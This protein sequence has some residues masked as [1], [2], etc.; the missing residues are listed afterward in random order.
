M[1]ASFNPSHRSAVDEL[2]GLLKERT[3]VESFLDFS[4]YCKSRREIHPQ[5]W[6]SAFIKAQA[7]GNPALMNLRRPNSFAL[8][9]TLFFPDAAIQRDRGNNNNGHGQSQGQQDQSQGQGFFPNV[10]TQRDQGNNNNG[11]GQGVGQQSQGFYPNA[12]IQRDRNDNNN[13]QGQPGQGF[14]RGKR[15][16]PVRHTHAQRQQPD[17]GGQGQSGANNGAQSQCYVV[18]ERV[19]MDNGVENLLWY[20]RQD[21]MLNGHHMIWHLL[22]PIISEKQI[23]RRGEFFSFFHHDIL[24][25]YAA[26]RLSNGFSDYFVTPLTLNYN[27]VLEQ[28][29]DS[30]LRDGVSTNFWIPRPSSVPVNEKTLDNNNFSKLL[31]LADFWKRVLD[32]ILTGTIVINGKPV[33]LT[34]ADN[35]NVIGELLEASVWSANPSFYGQMG[36]HNDAHLV[37]GSVLSNHYAPGIYGVMSSTATAM[38]DVLFYRVH[39]AADYMFKTYKGMA[40]EPYQLTGGE[41][42]L[43]F[44]GVAI[45]GLSVHVDLDSSPLQNRDHDPPANNLR[46]FWNMRRFQG[47]GGL[48][49][50]PNMTRNAPLVDAC[51]KFLDHD[52]FVYNIN[53]ENHHRDAV[54]AFVRIFM[55]PRFKPGGQER[56]TFEEQI[57]LFFTMDAFIDKIQP[58]R[59]VLTRHSQNSS[60][61]AEWP[62]SVPDMRDDIAAGVDDRVNC[63]CDYPHHLLLPK[64]LEGGMTFDLFVMITDASQDYLA[65]SEDSSMSQC[66]PSYIHCGIMG[67]AYPDKKPMGY[68]FDRK[69]LLLP[70]QQYGGGQQGVQYRPPPTI[71]SWVALVPNMASTQVAVIHRNVQVGRM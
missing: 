50:N 55:A 54:L 48:D 33:K 49:F 40:L 9:P 52:E 14:S 22:F 51:V 30:H 28:G 59:N 11:Q 12:A 42:P 46:T 18:D 45:T 63:E 37:I 56:F 47:E 57:P 17:G 44:Q 41:H 61:T 19:G 13:G 26:E 70:V 24:A 31:N 39:A 21:V 8:L 66:V 62:E 4:D 20:F 7:R 15:N 36:W 69:P 64:G 32:L 43:V 53:V 60:L 68:P 38:R 16:V 29:F 65:P 27:T 71:E 6:Y 34:Y 35:I 58:G 5:V 23:P 67:Q 25:R 10:A 2:E 3:D 1:F